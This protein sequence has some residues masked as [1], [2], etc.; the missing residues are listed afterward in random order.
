MP[1]R[2]WPKLRAGYLLD[3]L[4]RLDAKPTPFAALPTFLDWVGGAERSKQPSAGLGDDLRLRSEHVIGSGLDLDDELI[5]L[6]PL[7]A[8]RVAGVHSAGSRGRATD[9]PEYATVAFHPRQR[10][11]AFFDVSLPV[12]SHSGHW[13]TMRSRWARA[14]T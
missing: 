6:S 11:A 7:P 8:V 12:P 14:G 2:D 5:Q 13:V 4:G 9:D 10:Q 3:A 1:S